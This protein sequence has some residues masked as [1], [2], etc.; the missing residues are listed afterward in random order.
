VFTLLAGI[1][2]SKNGYFTVPA[3]VGCAIG[4]IGCGLLTMVDLD[5]GTKWIGY[6][7]CISAGVGMAIQQGFTAVQIVLPLN[8]VAIG[9]AAVVAF[10][11]LGGAIFV[12]VGNTILQSNLLAAD[13]DGRLPGVDIQAVIDAGAAAFRDVVPI[14][15]LPALLTVYNEALRQV[16]IAA[17]PLCGLAMVSACFLEWRD[18]KDQSRA[19]E[20]NDKKSAERRNEL[21]QAILRS[22]RKSL[23]SSTS[24]GWS[25]RS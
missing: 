6:E 4:T 21:E 9:T 17:I 15:Q 5:T 7:I 12:S 13:Q 10:Q 8:E 14:E 19:K 16:F 24:A 20:E 1:F 2:V 18:L 11:S 3:I 22:H 25:N 23:N